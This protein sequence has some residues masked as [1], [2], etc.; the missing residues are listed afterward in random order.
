MFESVVK[1]KVNSQLVIDNQSSDWKSQKAELDSRFWYHICWKQIFNYL[2]LIV[3]SD[4]LDLKG[5]IKN[6][7]VLI[8][9]TWILRHVSDSTVMS[10][11]ICRDCTLTSMTHWKGHLERTESEALSFLLLREL[12]AMKAKMFGWDPNLPMRIFLNASEF[13]A[14]CFVSQIQDHKERPL[15][16]DSF[17]FSKPERSYDTY[18]RELWVIIQFT[19][20]FWHFFECLIKSTIQWTEWS[21]CSRF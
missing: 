2:Q 8:I 5:D 21:C 7:Q 1:I 19:E 11:I 6:G 16:Y 13:T 10:Q 9:C 3:F 14:E 15:Y 17:T 4:S 12:C 20:K 18:K